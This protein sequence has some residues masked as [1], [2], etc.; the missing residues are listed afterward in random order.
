[1]GRINVTFTIFADLRDPTIRGNGLREA[2]RLFFF[3]A[4]VART[5]VEVW[6]CAA[7]ESGAYIEYPCGRGNSAISD[8]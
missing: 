8:A 6:L 5:G 1:M 7:S 3:G 4:C 2:K